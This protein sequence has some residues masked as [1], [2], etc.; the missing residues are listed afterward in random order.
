M[1]SGTDELDEV[2]VEPF[3]FPATFPPLARRLEFDREEPSAI[4]FPEGRMLQSETCSNAL[5]EAKDALNCQPPEQ[6]Y[7]NSPCVTTAQFA[8]NTAIAVARG[9][10]DTALAI[11]K[12]AYYAAQAELARRRIKEFAKA[13]IP[14]VC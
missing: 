6:V 3:N 11:A 2:Q 10:Y 13:L 7:V 1:I 9:E 4:K 14:C 12:A 5:N 8:Y